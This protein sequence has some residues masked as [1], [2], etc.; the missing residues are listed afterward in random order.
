V[1]PIDFVF[2]NCHMNGT[3]FVVT[4]LY[5]FYGLLICSVVAGNAV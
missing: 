2:T 5:V 4:A 1:T 3:L